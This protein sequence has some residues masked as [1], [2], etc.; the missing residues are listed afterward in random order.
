MSSDLK[1]AYVSDK[2]ARVI[3]TL[4]IQMAAE[5]GFAIL[6]HILMQ[7]EDNM[8]QFPPGEIGGDTAC[9]TEWRDIVVVEGDLPP[10]NEYATHVFTKDEFQEFMDYVEGMEQP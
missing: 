2:A 6:H 1:E 7:H 10:E 3:D 5:D 9:V 8:G 4:A